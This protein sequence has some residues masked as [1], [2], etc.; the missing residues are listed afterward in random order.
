M[1]AG[2]VNMARERARA[3]PRLERAGVACLVGTAAAHLVDLPGHAQD[4]PYMAVLFGLL[5]A[6]SI[7]LAG[8]IVRG[9][10]LVLVWR[11]AGGLAASAIAGFLLSRTIG[12]PQIEDHI[13]DWRDPVAIAA[14][15]FEGLLVAL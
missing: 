12:L 1:A 14:L 9:E 15:G 13:G 3:E 6:A 4:A 7:A 5:A 10:H 2:T 11:A 8:L